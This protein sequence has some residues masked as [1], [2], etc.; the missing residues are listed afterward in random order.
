MAGSA[1]FNSKAVAIGIRGTAGAIG[2]P[3]AAGILNRVRRIRRAVAAVGVAGRVRVVRIRAQLTPVLTLL[4]VEPW[5]VRRI[6]IGGRLIAKGIVQ[7]VRLEGSCGS[8]EMAATGSN[9]S[10][11][12]PDPKFMEPPS[13]TTRKECRFRCLFPHP[14]RQS[15]QTA[16]E[17]DEGILP[18]PACARENVR[19][20]ISD[21]K[22]CRAAS[23][24]SVPTSA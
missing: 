18:P 1:S 7:A 10:I 5:G 23:T 3:G 14:S 24:C 12:M 22:C 2:T 9:K 16:T 11:V 20:S 21:K 6:G 17:K 13:V 19:H 4:I 15:P 8:G